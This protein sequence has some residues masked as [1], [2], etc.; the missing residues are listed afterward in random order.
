MRPKIAPTWPTRW[1][2]A[3]T[4]SPWPDLIVRQSGKHFSFKNRQRAKA[5]FRGLVCRGHCFIGQQQA[6]SP[7]LRQ[8]G[9]R[10]T[11]KPGQCLDRVELSE[12]YRDG[13]RHRDLEVVRVDGL[14]ETASK[15]GDKLFDRYNQQTLLTIDR[16]SRP[17]ASP[18]VARM[19]HQR[20]AYLFF[21]HSGQSSA[22]F[23]IKLMRSNYSPLTESVQNGVVG[24]RGPGLGSMLHQRAQENQSQ[25]I[26]I[27]HRAQQDHSRQNPR[28]A[29]VGI[30]PPSSL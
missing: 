9:G 12:R 1:D 23:T 18:C 6:R 25:I 29:N 20:L 2:A 8:A 24:K 27:N 28:T 10:R 3:A 30:N 16:G 4:R 22:S 15:P 5:R 19:H 11:L 21:Q 14:E 13:G 17:M 26:Q 7:C